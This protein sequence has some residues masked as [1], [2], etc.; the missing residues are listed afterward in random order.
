MAQL[1]P[2]VEG[3]QPCLHQAQKGWVRRFCAIA[4]H[5]QGL[6]SF[7]GAVQSLPKLS[8]A[9]CLS[10]AALWPALCGLTQ[11]RAWAAWRPQRAHPGTGTAS[12]CTRGPL[13]SFDH[14]TPGLEKGQ[15]PF[16]LA[17]L[18]SNPSWTGAGSPS[19]PFPRSCRRSSRLTLSQA[20]L[21]ACAG[22]ILTPTAQAPT[23]AFPPFLF[24]GS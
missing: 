19:S 5:G 23:E 24:L 2:A 7:C 10:L 17:N 21:L 20:G 4:R 12:A 13:L 22:A 18:F 3:V 1:R 6:Q 14:F 9:Q 8:P 16:K 15:L 11:A